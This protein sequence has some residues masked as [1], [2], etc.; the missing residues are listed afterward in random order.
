[1]MQSTK[2]IAKE[3][4]KYLL[5]FGI[6]FL[7]AIVFGEFEWLFFVILLIILFL[8]REPNRAISSNDEFAILSPI[9]GKIISIEKISYF[10]TECTQIVIC[11][12]IFGA[13][14]IKAP[15]DMN[16]VEFKQRHGLFLCSF[17][18]AANF[19][20]ERALYIAVK[21]KNKIALRLISGAMSRNLYAEKFDSIKAGEKFGFMSDG[22]VAL[23]LPANTRISVVVG[24]RLK[25][26][27]LIGF[28]NYEGKR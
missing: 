3:G 8:F 23:I 24:E 26:S 28:F 21:G 2:I 12:T 16:L 20:N 22:K 7:I 9:D 17:M 4:Y 13:G 19:L 14:A 25:A 27:S 10:D 5:I 6:L 15:C 1:M 11:K 18:K